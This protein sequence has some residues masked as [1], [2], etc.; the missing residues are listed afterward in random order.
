MAFMVV[1]YG[2]GLAFTTF[3]FGGWPRLSVGK[4]DIDSYLRY[5]IEMQSPF[6]LYFIFIIDYY[7]SVF[8]CK[9]HISYYYLASQV[10]DRTG[11]PE[12]QPT[13]WLNDVLH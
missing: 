4:Q 7:I 12:Q 11:C 13:E 2:I 5:L 6:I 10:I 1:W 9:N 3:L 8:G